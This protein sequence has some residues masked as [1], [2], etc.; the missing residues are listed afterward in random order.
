MPDRFLVTGGL[1]CIGAWV[2]HEL[3]AEQAE[4][5][6]AD[7]GTADHRLR[8]LVGAAP[9]GLTRVALDITDA[10][11]VAA[12]FADERPTHVIHLAALQVPFCK[13]D[14][15]AG[16][17]V[18]VVGTISLLEAMA[19]H[20][21]DRVFAYASSVAAYGGEDEPTE[22]GVAAADPH[23]K[24]RT[25]YGV[26]KRANE[27]SAGVYHADRGLSSIGLRPYVVYGVGRDQG[28][29]S[30]PNMAML[31]AAQGEPFHIAY[32]G[33]AVYQ[34]GRDAA[35]AFIAAARADYD[36]ATVVNLPGDEVSMHDIIAAI[37]A[38]V[39]DAEITLDDVQLPFPPS[40]DASA[41]D[42]VVG[43][44]E[45]YPL[46]EGVAETIGRF[47]ALL[48]EGAEIVPQR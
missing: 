40:V 11:A 5:V 32:G 14:P 30:S 22:D 16:A 10:D 46:D 17:R 41:F 39:P 38:V 8:N 7:L 6:I 36:G 24:P 3:L 31:A 25:L 47:R 35:R 13:A 28:V 27:E 15:V 4:V 33:R 23:G 21:P 34:H 43:A 45:R 1:G 42:G 37:H 18:N 12:C 9:A 19:E 20:L 44:I 29:T 2:A 26:Y 48:D